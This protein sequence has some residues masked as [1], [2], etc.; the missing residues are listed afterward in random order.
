MTITFKI[1]IFYLFA[2]LFTNALILF[3]TF[4]ST[5]TITA[6]CFKTFFDSF[7]V[8]PDYFDSIPE[9]K[10][11]FAEDLIFAYLFGAAATAGNVISIIKARKNGQ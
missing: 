9:L 4:Q 6:L 11:A 3:C 7:N 1:R 8:V 5:R 2:E 10:D